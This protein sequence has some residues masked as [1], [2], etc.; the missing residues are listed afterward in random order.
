MLKKK[1]SIICLILLAISYSIFFL[2]TKEDS[3]YVSKVISPVE[4]ILENNQNFFIK[5]VDYF[6][7][8]FS[9][10]NKIF[11]E[12]FNLSEEESYIIGNLGKY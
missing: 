2:L 11:A 4:F 9:E 8:Y 5:G 6:D 12:K 10:K 1:I 3:F 7:S